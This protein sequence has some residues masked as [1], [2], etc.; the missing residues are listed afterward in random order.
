MVVRAGTEFPI[1]MPD[2]RSTRDPRLNDEYLR[3]V[4]GD[5]DHGRVVLVGAVHD[6]PASQYRA[7]SVVRDADPEVLALELPPLAVPLFEQYATGDRSPPAFGGEMSA[8]IQAA[9]TDR[10]VGVDGPTAG[11][12][13]RLVRTMYREDASLSTVRSSLRAFASVTRHAAVCR[14]VA[15]VVAHTSLA[16]EVDPATSYETD[17]TDDPVDQ[18]TDERDHVRRAQFVLQAFGSSQSGELRDATREAHMADRIA[19]L[20]EDGDVVAVVGIDH[21]D[22]IVDVIGGHDRDV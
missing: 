8:A 20:R 7:A 16:I 10:V 17:R 4:P 15:S 13:S 11:F 5:D 1:Q 14:F 9:A 22:P 12:A 21:L 3:T 19:D 18:A 2:A 6:H